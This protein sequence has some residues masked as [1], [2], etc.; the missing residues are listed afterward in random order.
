[1]SDNDMV[2]DAME[3]LQHVKNKKNL[4][5]Y[6]E[7]LNKN[8]QNQLRAKKTTLA[9]KK[10]KTISLD[11]LRNNIRIAFSGLSLML[12]SEKFYTTEDSDNFITYF[13]FINFTLYTSY[14]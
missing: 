13:Y 2:N 1:M 11:L 7:Q 3:G 6:V 8:L 5:V 14:F 12:S 4:Q 10:T 9:K